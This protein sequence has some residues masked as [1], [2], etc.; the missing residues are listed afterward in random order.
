M[1]HL[2]RRFVKPSQSPLELRIRVLHEAHQAVLEIFSLVEQ[3]LETV[4]EFRIGD[5]PVQRGLHRFEQDLGAVANF[6]SQTKRFGNAGI[7]LA[8]DRIA[9]SKILFLVTENN[10]YLAF[11][12]DTDIL[13]ADFGILRDSHIVAEADGHHDAVAGKFDVFNLTEFDAINL[14]RV[15][16][17]KGAHLRKL[18]MERIEFFPRVLLV[19]E[20]NAEHQ[21]NHG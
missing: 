17:D 15:I 11:A 3:G 21:H 19:Q 13:D 6:A 10:A 8:V 18:Q 7:E 2:A 16:Q 5:S 4:L 14:D 20:E 12:H 9:R 1:V